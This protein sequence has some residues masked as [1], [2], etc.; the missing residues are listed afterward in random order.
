MT[1]KPPTVKSKGG[2]GFM[3]ADKVAA[4]FIAN[5]IAFRAPLGIDLGLIERIEFERKEAGWILD[6]ML[7]ILRDAHGIRHVAAFSI[8][9]NLQF[10]K[11]TA[12][13]EFVEQ[14]WTQ[15]LKQESNP[16]DPVND[17]LG[18]ITSPLEIETEQTLDMFVNLA[19]KQEPEQLNNEIGITASE[20]R[21][22][23]FS[24]FSC[25]DSLF[26]AE[27]AK[28][29]VGELMRVLRFPRQNDFDSPTSQRIEE[30]IAR[31]RDVLISENLEEA[32]QVWGT[33]VRAGQEYITSGGY[34]DLDRAFDQLRPYRFKERPEHRPAWQRWLESSQAAIRRVVDT[35]GGVVSLSR[36]SA[37]EI[38]E[39]SFKH[40]L[41]VLVGDSG[42]GKSV[43]ARRWAES[44]L[45]T[46]NK[47]IWLDVQVLEWQ[48]LETFE[49]SLNLGVDLRALL[50][51]VFDSRATLV[52][53]GLDR[54]YD[55]STFSKIATLVEMLQLERESSPWHVILTCQTPEWSRVEQELRRVSLTSWHIVT[56]PPPTQEELQPVWQAFP[57]IARLPFQP[58]LQGIMGNLQILQI[59]TLNLGSSDSQTWVSESD[60]IEW[61]WSKLF[62]NSSRSRFAQRLAER[63]ADDLQSEISEL[64]FD[65]SQL[66]FVTSLV[67]DRICHRNQ[68]RIGFEHDLYGDWA[69]Q[70]I[71]IGQR[72]QIR[73]YL[74]PRMVS[75][76][77]HR[78]VRLY[79]QFLL[80]RN[81]DERAWKMAIDNLS[82]GTDSVA[83]DLMLE[84]PAFAADSATLLERVA[85]TLFAEKGRLLKRL[86]D[87]FLTSATVP[88]TF[89][90]AIALKSGVSEEAAKIWLRQPN[91]F[92]F[93]WIGI[94]RFLHKHQEVI[95]ETAHKEIAKLVEF[96]L[97]GTPPEYPARH[98]AS[99]LG[100]SLGF[101]VLHEQE[102]RY[103]LARDTR[104]LLYKVALL[105]AG[106][107]PDQTAQ[108]ALIAS[109]RLR[110]PIRYPA[111]ELPLEIE[112]V[113]QLSN[114]YLLPGDLPT[115]RISVSH[116]DIYHADKPIPEP[117]SDGPSERINTEF[118]K[119][120]LDQNALISLMRV[121][122]AVAR[123][124]LLAVLIKPPEHRWARSWSE[125]RSFQIEPSIGWHPAFYTNGNFLFFLQHSFDEGLEFVLR[126]VQFA[127]ER[128]VEETIQ[129]SQELPNDWSVLGKGASV[130]EAQDRAARQTP[131][132]LVLQL[133]SGERKLA[134]DKRV[135]AW[136]RGLGLG[137]T[138]PPIEIVSALMALEQ[139][140]YEKIKLG[141]DVSDLAQ[142]ILERT[143]NTAILGVLSAI[144]RSQPGLLE[145]VLSPLIRKLEIFHWDML[146]T[147]HDSSKLHLMIGAFNKGQWFVDLAQ[148]FHGLEHRNKNLEEVVFNRMFSSPE[149]CQHLEKARQEWILLLTHFQDFEFSPQYVKRM[150]I[151]LDPTNWVDLGTSLVNQKLADLQAE[152]KA[153][154]TNQMFDNG[155]F[156]TTFAFYC[157]Q[158]LESN[159]PL[160]GEQLTPF[161]ESIE[162]AQSL[163]ETSV[164]WGMNDP[165]ACIIGGIAVLARL[166][167]SWLEL[168]EDRANWCIAT[169]IEIGTR[170]FNEPLPTSL[171]FDTGWEWQSF[172][173][174]VVPVFWL[175]NPDNQALRELVLMLLLRGSHNVL[176]TLMSECGKRR[177][178]FG[179]HFQQLWR[180][181][182]EF[183]SVR[184][185]LHMIQ[186]VSHYADPDKLLLNNFQTAMEKW[187]LTWIEDFIKGISIPDQVAWSELSSHEFFKDIDAH[188]DQFQWAKNRSLLDMEYVQ[189]TH[190]WLEHL[191]DAKSEIERQTWINFWHQALDTILIRAIPQ[192]G[193]YGNDDSVD[194]P[195]ATELW[196]LKC[197]ALLLVQLNESENPRAF[198]EPILSLSPGGRWFDHQWINY[199]LQPWHR[200]A[201]QLN[202]VPQEYV[203]T[204]VAML[205]FAVEQVHMN[206]A[207]VRYEEPW[208]SLIGVDSS[209]REYWK[210][211]HKDT[212]SVLRDVFLTWANFALVK[213]RC[214]APFAYFL[215]RDA[216]ESIRIDGL[217]AL[218]ASIVKHPGIVEDVENQNALA[219]L[220][221]VVWKEHESFL[222]GQN[223][224]L[225][226]FQEILRTLI[227]R[228]HPLALE[229]LSRMASN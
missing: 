15:F 93:H 3:F 84:A 184:Q 211:R 214:I 25:P 18:L 8:K 200:N 62:S 78:A 202:P 76:L 90:V 75:P 101:Y 229:L 72:D 29:L 176:K 131:G 134:G 178:Q 65:E 226:M 203:A 161:W 26:A 79:G 198:W 103:H 37:I 228:N 88:D 199:F 153:D 51:G 83:Q 108:F 196:V 191:A 205:E 60:V 156:L 42:V 70:R 128:W 95:L 28:P 206:A 193:Q 9:S 135:F 171:E 87:R 213:S 182:L 175:E 215:T 150:V 112:P 107:L 181:V 10:G 19:L 160:R 106:E 125:E 35:L 163:K 147:I 225:E 130:W 208:L 27:Q 5:M 20:D 192:K 89:R 132:Y 138:L 31:I 77:W 183:A 43:V 40:K 24:S 141:E 124:V 155:R 133:E 64:V 120:V 126:I 52:L 34:I 13:K 222:R 194:F 187:Q 6:D 207:W 39:N 21:Q 136:Y 48:T 57:A 67:Q 81:T 165:D 53:D 227:N 114:S 109:K 33:L 152:Y 94:I 85:S 58:R 149:I 59:I 173:A 30:A 102:R 54:V 55:S 113:D 151:E 179:I 190:S 140:F 144:G 38:L 104:L 23:L 145:N 164:D 143:H 122:P 11:T 220:L 12:P 188:F 1:R 204:S 197:T 216:A 63:Q 86:L 146:T 66:Q 174:H 17:I 159:E 49:A 162:R 218:K 100:L 36:D 47:V 219:T 41:V 129:H 223:S 210:P 82:T 14:A 98:E 224:Q 45:V 68:E 4:Y 217:E 177:Q 69:R 110:E 71:L 56:C 170:A 158:I 195:N 169:L 119:V 212:V 221:N 116:Y 73:T 148:T 2:G 16:F 97:E 46:G 166:N 127:A 139:I 209:T 172:A 80:E 121:Q 118:R 137:G 111:Q 74:E 105:A 123:E 22:K 201:L 99:E 92:V 186:G 61:F 32:I 180:F 50:R 91:P 167:R 154:L 44:E 157:H 142:H 168:H 189:I 96:W 115:G 117:W 7:L 185:R